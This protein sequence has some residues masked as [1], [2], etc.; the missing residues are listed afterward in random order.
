M[1]LVI[2]ENLTGNLAPMLRE[3]ELDCVLIALPFA[4]PGVKTR[5]AV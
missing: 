5:V 3:G 1:P 2:E 4:L